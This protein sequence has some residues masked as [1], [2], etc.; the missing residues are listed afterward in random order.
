MP[1]ADL[2]ELL[3]P[4]IGHDERLERLKAL[5]YSSADYHCAGMVWVG[6]FFLEP[7]VTDRLIAYMEQNGLDRTFPK[8]E[9]LAALGDCPYTDQE[10]NRT[11]EDVLS[12]W[13]AAGPKS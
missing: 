8:I 4:R 3:R 2:T 11:P 5:G 1:A 10:D 12:A 6:A 7:S 13:E 9:D